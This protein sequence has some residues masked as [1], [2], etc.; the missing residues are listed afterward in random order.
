MIGSSDKGWRWASARNNEVQPQRVPGSAEA[1]IQG[2]ATGRPLQWAR[3]DRPA[4][5]AAY[6]NARLVS[7]WPTSPPMLRRKSGRPP[8]VSPPTHGLT[9]GVFCYA[10]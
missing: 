1:G 8:T 6:L 2:A 9:A 10:E 7:P 5:L 3:S 4:A